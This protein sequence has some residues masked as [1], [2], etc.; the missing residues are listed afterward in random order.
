MVCDKR[1]P[2]L[3]VEWQR[4]SDHFHVAGADGLV[5]ARRR[6]GAVVGGGLAAWRGTLA[7][8]DEYQADSVGLD[9]LDVGRAAEDVE[10]AQG[11]GDSRAV[12]EAG[13]HILGHWEHDAGAL[14]AG[15]LEDEGVHG[16]VDVD[17]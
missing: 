3:C 12:E 4:D 17:P 15:V 10:D 6:I 8:D 9:G 2:V 7:G 13:V 14:E 16:V 1:R 5:D 11:A